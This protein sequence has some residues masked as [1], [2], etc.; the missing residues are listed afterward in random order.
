MS[1]LTKILDWKFNTN[2]FEQDFNAWETVKAKYEQQTGQQLPDSILVATMMNKTTGAL[3][4]HLR[5]NAGNIT[6]FAQ[7]K[8]LLVQYFRSR[9]IINIQDTSGP[10]DI[11]AIKGKGK[12]KGKGGKSN[13]SHWNFMKGKGSNKGKGKGKH[14]KGDKG[15]GK[16]KQM[17]QTSN[18]GKG[19]GK[20]G[21]G[22]VCWTCGAHGRINAVDDTSLNETSW[23]DEWNEWTCNDPTYFGEFDGSWQDDHFVGHVGFDD[24][25]TDDWTSW[26]D[27]SWDQT[28]T[29]WNEAGQASTSGTPT[30]QEAQTRTSV[31]VTEL[32]ASGSAASQGTSAQVS[33]VLAEPPGRQ[34]SQGSRPTPSTSRG[35]VPSMMLAAITLNAFGVGTSVS[36]GH[37]TTSG[38][39][40]QH[41]NESTHFQT[42]ESVGLSHLSLPAFSDF[43]MNQHMVIASSVD[44]LWVLFDSAH[45]CPKNFAPEWPLLPLNGS[46][47]PLRSVTGQPLHVYGRKLVG[48]KVGEVDFFLHF[49]VTDIDYPLVS[50]GRVLV[51]GYTVEL[52]EL[53]MCMKCPGGQSMPL[54]RHGSLLF[55]Q[56][57]IQP[58]EKN[59]FEAVCVTFHE[60][61]KP[62]TNTS[63]EEPP[64]NLV[65]PT[66]GS[67]KPVYYH[68][69][70]WYFDSSR[71]RYHRR[72]RRNLFTPEGTSDR[73]DMRSWRHFEG[74]LSLTKTRPKRLLKTTGEF[75]KII[76]EP[77]VSSGKA[78]RSLF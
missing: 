61:F 6:T 49:Y 24:W 30:L 50:V 67:F 77:W 25:R 2:T 72:P 17:P 46:K 40:Q 60:Q 1:L 45:C 34:V 39:V 51:Q 37:V 75:Q 13:F 21:A 10:M 32:P 58:F 71:H 55:M 78:G 31:Q 65:A 38:S 73:L 69:D 7:V 26:D 76:R 28:W 63:T 11:G 33:A 66:S 44:T 36:L 74:L 57:S 27:W 23:N 42:L 54:H 52:S 48:M 22:L 62:K 35:F 18:K 56:P 19:K 5:L 9:H 15:K 59:N 12:Y 43:M 16:G 64:E 53:Q 41:Q 47:P 8:Q 29:S 20:G 68:T 3:Q 14:F 70:R 4:Q